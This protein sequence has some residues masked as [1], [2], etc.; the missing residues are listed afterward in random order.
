[1]R[2][3]CRRGAVTG[4]TASSGTATTR[5]GS[6]VPK[7]IEALSGVRV[8][9]VSAGSDHTLF[10]TEGGRVYSCGS[11]GSGKLGHG[12]TELLDVPKAIIKP[13]SVSIFGFF[14]PIG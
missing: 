8:C 4:P 3:V 6:R 7:L 9:A 13:L 11:G 10:L 14:A 12:N 2:R 5:I 1:M